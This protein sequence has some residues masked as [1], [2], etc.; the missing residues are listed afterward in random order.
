MTEKGKQAGTSDGGAEGAWLRQMADAPV[1]GTGLPDP[2]LLWWKA[3]AL[4][5]RDAAHRPSA[6][7]DCIQ[8]I[9]ASLAAVLLLAY[10]LNTRS[11][12]RTP[13]VVLPLASG[14]LLLVVGLV[15]TGAM[16]R[17]PR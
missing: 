10:L 3:Q 15:I 7:A 4:C 14:V 5:R 12:T 13:D 6:A 8:V 2:Q 1:E 16:M 9:A 11:L 17:R